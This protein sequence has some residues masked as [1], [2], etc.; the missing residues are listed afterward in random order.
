MPPSCSVHALLL[1]PI[2]CDVMED[3]VILLPAGMTYDRKQICKSLLHHPNLDPSSG[4]RYDSKL[5]YC[6]NVVVRQLL[7]ETYGDKAYRRYDDSGFQPRYQEAW[8]TAKVV[9]RV[10]AR[11]N[12]VEAYERVNALLWGMNLSQINL[13]GA[14]ELVEMLP[15]DAVM[16]VL[17]AMFL[18]P[19][20]PGLTVESCVKD[21]GLARNAWDRA[22]GLGLREQAITGNAWAQWA[23]GRRQ[24]Y[25]E[26][27]YVAALEWTRKA[28]DQG[29]AAAQWALGSMYGNG[30][31]V[32]KNPSLALEWTRKAADQGFAVAQYCLGVR[33]DEGDLG[34]EK[35]YRLAV[36][37][38]RKAA[39]Q[40]LADSQSVLGV[41]YSKGNGVEQSYTF[42]LD[43]YRK[44]AAQGN[45]R[46]QCNLGW[47]YE[48]GLGVAKSYTSAVDWYRK[49]AAQGNSSAQCNL[50]G[51]YSKGNGV[52]QSY[53]FAVDWYRKAAAK[54]NS[55]AQCNLGALY[56][57][58]NGVE[59]SYTYALDWYRK[60]AA[61]G[62]SQAQCNLGW[63]YER[64][65]GVTKSTSLA[66]E[67]Y[68]KA[69]IQGDD[70]AKGRLQRLQFYLAALS[71]VD[72]LRSTL[73]QL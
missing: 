54:G 60:A 65:L 46:A 64:G 1:C 47:N 19:E 38:H 31:G 53:T 15:E 37:W 34:V 61:K 22:L 33:Y 8:N 12:S 10:I 70:Y 44:A 66:V 30:L 36:E 27:N 62:N 58:G 4:V 41:L 5:Q 17:K 39:E 57:K 32:A 59:Q 40:G 72:V 48:R 23:E 6:D 63:N 9:G 55:Q 25:R 35:N 20:I 52:E 71:W 42:A 16:V 45:S 50:G 67:W 29:F 21:L 13:K 24:F 56:Y 51:L 69:A 3:P 18:D 11:S 73:L 43:W 14:L 49:A 26:T 7:M 28:A 2:S 68:Q